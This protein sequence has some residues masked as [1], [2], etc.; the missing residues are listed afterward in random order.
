MLRHNYSTVIK[1]QENVPS[2]RSL[3][4]NNNNVC[5]KRL[6]MQERR[7]VNL[8]VHVKQSHNHINQIFWQNKFIQKEH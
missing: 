6:F 5:M 8:A 4:N 2:H 3:V 1:F 7:R